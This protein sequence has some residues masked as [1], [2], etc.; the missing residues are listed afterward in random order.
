[1]VETSKDLQIKCADCYKTF[2]SGTMRLSA[3]KKGMVC[4]DCNAKEAKSKSALRNV[5][6][7]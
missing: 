5:H 7:L 2:P 4:P 3:V 1:M 6:N